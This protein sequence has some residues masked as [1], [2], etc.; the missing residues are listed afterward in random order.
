VFLICLLQKFK[1]DDMLKI[2]LHK[3]SVEAASHSETLDQL[4][5]LVNGFF[6]DPGVRKENNI[7]SKV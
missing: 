6:I 7:S 2:V 3:K 5:I 4:K 1:V